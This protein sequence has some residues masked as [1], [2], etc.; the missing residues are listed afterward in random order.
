MKRGRP[1]S[2]D[3]DYV[4]SILSKHKDALFVPAT[5][6]IL[7]KGD[8]LWDEI[9]DELHQNKNARNVPKSAKAL[10]TYVTCRKPFVEQQMTAE[11]DN[12][13]ICQAFFYSLMLQVDFLLVK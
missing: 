5:K 4:L 9:V 11:I 6:K 2:I 10:Y 1:E 8:P 7:S 3:K 13:N 12:V